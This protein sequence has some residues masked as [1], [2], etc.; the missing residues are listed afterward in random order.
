L[1]PI[2]RTDTD[3]TRQLRWLSRQV[4]PVAKRLEKVYGRDAVLAVLFDA[5]DPGTVLPIEIESE[6][7]LR[8]YDEWTIARSS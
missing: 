1:G 2:G 5:L 7:E 4:A 8:D 6:V 3:A